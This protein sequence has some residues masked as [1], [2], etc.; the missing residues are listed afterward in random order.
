MISRSHDAMSRI[1]G[2]R[3]KGY[4][5]FP[6]STTSGCHDGTISGD[7]EVTILRYYDAMIA[8][9]YIDCQHAQCQSISIS[10]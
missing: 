8:Q 4:D 9:Y 1:Y 6:V 7:H 5:H 3:M 10:V 2:V